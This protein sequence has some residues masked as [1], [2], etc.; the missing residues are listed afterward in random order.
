MK[1]SVKIAGIFAVVAFALTAVSANAAFMRDLTLGSTGADVTE[2]QNILISNGY[3]IPAGATGYFGAQTQAALAK[4]QAAVGISP[5]AGYFGPITRA[6]L[7]G[8]PSTPGNPGTPSTPG[9]DDLE[10]GSGD[11]TV[12]EKS[13]GTEDEVL[14]GEEE[15]AVL[16]FEVEAEGSDVSLTSV[17]VEFE[18]AG[19]NTGSDKLDRYID[20]VQIMLGDEVVGS[21]DVD[22]FN[23]ND[24]VYSESIQLDGAIIREDDTE[25]LYVSVTAVNNIDSDDISEDWDVT[26]DQTRFEDAEGAVLTYTTSGIA[27][28][29]TFEDLSTSG[30]IS[31]DISEDD[32]TINS[33]HSVQ[34]DDSSDTNDVEILSFELEA[35]GTDIFF[36]EL[37]F[38]ITSTGAGITEIANDFR[39]MMDGEEVGDLASSTAS[40]SATTGTFVFNDLDDDD[41]VVEEGDT[42][43]FT[44]LADINEIGGGFTNGDELAVVLDEDGV[45][46]EDENGDAIGTDDISGSAD[47]TGIEFLAAGISV[48]TDT[49][50]A[51][52]DTKVS[53]VATDDEGRFEVVFVVKAVDEA[54]YIELGSATRGTTE[55]NTG[56]NFVIQ[57]AD[58]SYA[59]T[60]TGN[61]S[62]ADVTRV[63]GG[64]V[65]GEFIKV[66]AGSEATFKLVVNFDPAHTTGTAEAYRLRLYSVNFA[67]T[68]ADATDQQVLTPE[69]DYRTGSVSIGN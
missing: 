42:V 67:A 32:E 62:L 28:T 15:V 45:D 27:A 61:I 9:S 55:S 10:G 49:T 23:E 64:S 41:V 8:T 11:I 63:S 52:V 6:K 35:E 57:D 60:S 54:A 20:E 40:S 30:D 69:V 17:K 50:D 58:N 37:S 47:S 16:G 48:E 44:L 66:N 25:K 34:V 19:A 13:S 51:E 29:F 33:A 53:D 59:A 7:A 38:D 43:T 5:A 12:N 68:A 36:N 18:Y 3:S 39:L 21:A 22:S 1:F 24:D 56:V 26:L 2:L 65:S 46:A 14:E 31:L 4:W